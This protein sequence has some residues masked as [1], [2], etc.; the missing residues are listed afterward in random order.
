MSIRA[1]WK[2]G[3]A[4]PLLLPDACSQPVEPLPPGVVRVPSEPPPPL[5]PKVA[6]F[7]FHKEADTP[8][9]RRETEEDRQARRYL[10]TLGCWP[11]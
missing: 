10:E 4:P 2:D 11:G 5:P 9:W 7:W 3:V 8:P 6:A 1:R